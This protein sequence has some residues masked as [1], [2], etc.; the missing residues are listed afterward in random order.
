MTVLAATNA[1]EAID[2]AFLRPGR[3]DR[4]VYVPL[5]DARDRVEILE[6]LRGRMRWSPA[7]D[8]GCVGGRK[9]GSALRFP[10]HPHPCMLFPSARLL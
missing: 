9:S 4:L 7:V 1:P 10:S 2:P 8:T 5:P 6:G 3:F